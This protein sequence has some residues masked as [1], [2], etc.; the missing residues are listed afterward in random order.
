MSKVICSGEKRSDTFVMASFCKINDQESQR[1]E[2]MVAK[3]ARLP[4]PS[5]LQKAAALMKRPLRPSVS[6]GP[7]GVDGTGN[8]GKWEDGLA[9]R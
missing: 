7:G 2:V 1:S 8:Q 9:Q 5:C 3:L 4:S 6:P